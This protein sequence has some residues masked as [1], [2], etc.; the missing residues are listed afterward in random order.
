MNTLIIVGIVVYAVS[1]FLS[2][3]WTNIAY[4]KGGIY[5]KLDVKKIDFYTSFIPILNTV[6]CVIFWI[7]WFPIERKKS[8]FATKFFRIKK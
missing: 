3:I 8:D 4:S 6:K 5:N 7:F 1:V 2:Y